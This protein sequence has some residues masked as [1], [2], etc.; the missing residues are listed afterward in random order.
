MSYKPINVLKIAET[1][2]LIESGSDDAD[3]PKI[4]YYS[5]TNELIYIVNFVS[6]RL[7]HYRGNT[8]INHQKRPQCSVIPIFLTQLVLDY[9]E[10]PNEFWFL[11]V[12]YICRKVMTRISLCGFFIRVRT[13]RGRIVSSVNTFIL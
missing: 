8:Y 12:L 2:K 5:K 1:Q 13:F 6:Y 3:D 9:R 10:K 7:T 11:A 4:C